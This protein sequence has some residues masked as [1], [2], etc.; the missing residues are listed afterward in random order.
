MILLSLVVAVLL[1]AAP[2][3]AA[4]PGGPSVPPPA[5]PDTPPSA[6]A[7]QQAGP[8]ASAIQLFAAV[9]AA[10]A[11]SDGERLAALVDTTRVLIGLKPDAPPATA[12]TRV[13]A[14]FLFTDQMRLVSTR[15]FRVVKIEV[16]GKGPARATALWTGDWGGRQG[17]RRVQ[18]ELRGGQAQ[19]GWLL[20]EV[21]ASD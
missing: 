20:T 10:W 12:V 7:S 17:V 1:G 21:R 5:R 2:A 9:E 3:S 16:P 18:V 14:A 6:F 19:G 8:P 15:E 11:V 4:A 13:A